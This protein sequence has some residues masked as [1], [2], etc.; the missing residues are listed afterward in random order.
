M[1]DWLALNR[2]DFLAA[3]GAT[4]GT[5]ACAM[6]AP[7]SWFLEY[8]R[9][10]GT[11]PSERFV[12]T[13]CPMCPGGCGLNVRTVHGYAV[14]VKGN[15]DHPINRGGLC[16][17]ASVVLQ[18]V[19]NPDRLRHPLQAVGAKGSGKFKEI[20]WDQAIGLLTAKLADVRGRG[21]QGLCT[22]LGRDRGLSRT[23]WI[24]FMR[25][26]GSPNL[27][28]EAPDDNLGA[29]PVVLAAQGV[30][31]RMGHDVAR[32]SFVLSLSSGWL[33]AHWST[34]QAAKGF[35]D[36]RRGRPGFRPRWVHV[37]PRFSLTAAKADEW[38]AIRPGT[39]GVLALGLAH[40]MVREGLYDRSYVDRFAYGFDDFTD[41][42]G[43]KH[44]GFRRF[45]L[46]EFPPAKVQSITGVADGDVFRLA[47]ELT[48]NRP[49]IVLG[50]DG[51]G[52]GQQAAYD[53]MAIH[54]LNALNG[55]IDVPG[56][57]TV[58][59][60]FTLGAPEVETDAIAER[61]LA[62]QRLDGLPRQRRLSDHPIDLLAEALEQGR[63]FTPD[64]VWLADADPVFS[65][66]QGDGFANGLAKVPF[67]VATSQYHNDSTQFADLILPTLHGLH[68]WDYDVSSTLTGHPVVTLAQP[69]MPPPPGA[70]DPYAVLKIMADAMGGTVATS[71]PW[72]DSQDA[73]DA[74]CR[75]LFRRKKGAAFGPADEESWAQLLE[76]RG[77][78]APFAGDF[79]EF[80]RDLLAGG[81][82]TD[83]I[84]TH[85]EWD[86]V[87]RSPPRKF[88]FSSLHL[89]RSFEAF[90]EPAGSADAGV[91]CLPD[92]GR[93]EPAHDERHPF[94]LYVYPLPNLV[95]VSSPN[96]PWLNDLAGAYMFEKWRTWVEIHPE[97]AQRL[98]V[99]DQ[100]L[101][102]VRTP[103][104]T[105]T[106]P[107]KT[108]EGLMPEVIAI[109]FG[110]GHEAGGR[111]CA[112]IGANPAKL[113]EARR[114]PLTGASL[115]TRT[116]ASVVKV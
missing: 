95:G 111:W 116:R 61:G 22:V 25:A 1:K 75:E 33:D 109:P 94:E 27:F 72:S 91:R 54:C 93:D 2:R 42:E 14:G 108:Y 38:L 10:E 29:D 83:P 66:P 39:E 70:K 15:D 112:G 114:D 36:F 18:D 82:W 99:E 98:G 50:F 80:K 87:F 62:A 45:V 47:R 13:I 30:R 48:A 113:V 105:L 90:E 34:V 6:A 107:V 21:P 97:M 35:A 7:K 46:Q 24:R 49:A 102:E 81:G 12:N 64:V 60:D 63:P 41:R 40:V 84:Y 79:V 89:A 59:T 76:E 4:Y 74:V 103:R 88:A 31:Q 73:V 26:F 37:E 9:S 55:S 17:R 23:A 104:G 106:L 85:G 65:L 43:R 53:R 57:V 78:C 92:C 101:V 5:A 20:P 52:C 28:E 16:S 68:R 51:G 77:W 110:F 32:A 11:P 71:L 56:G 58:F 67:V 3:L 96:L 86:R 19:Y 44:R 115:W 100:D 8:A 69:V